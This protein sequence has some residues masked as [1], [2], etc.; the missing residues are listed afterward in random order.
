MRI[1]IPMRRLALFAI[2]FLGALIL[3]LPL[4]LALD[5]SGIAAREAAGSMWAGTLK[6]ARIGPALL[7]DLDARLSPFALLTGRIRLAVARPSAAPD[8]FTGAFDL[9]RHRRAIESATGLV[10]VESGFGA[11]PV[12]SLELT[13]LTIR[14]RD[15]ECDRA[16]GMVRAN[17]SGEA[18]GLILP[19]SLAGAARCDRGAVLIP[20]GGGSGTEQIDLRLFGDGRWEARAAVRGNAA[21]FNGR[22]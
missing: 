21:A 4:R 12:T 6:E 14:F 10:S 7:G 20:L 17:L 18:V 8:R 16:Q 2:L 11:L 22:F 5:G 9:S 3:F 19:S 1:A 13:D 15:G